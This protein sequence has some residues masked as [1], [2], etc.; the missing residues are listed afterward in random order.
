ME[1]S[2]RQRSF[3]E[4]HGSTSAR[5][6]T[7]GDTS[8]SRRT[9]DSPDDGLFGRHRPAHSLP[10]PFH[11]PPLLVRREHEPFIRSVRF[12]QAET[13]SEDVAAGKKEHQRVLDTEDAARGH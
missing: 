5:P 12:N 4:R 10:V 9:T 3:D 2:G 13:V 6:D 8:S 1:V 7:Y 11:A